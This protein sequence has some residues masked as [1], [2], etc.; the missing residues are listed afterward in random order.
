MNGGP[1]GATVATVH[2]GLCF[3]EKRDSDKGNNHQGG[4]SDDHVTDMISCGARSYG[5]L[6]VFS[7]DRTFVRIHLTLLSRDW[8]AARPSLQLVEAS[9]VPRSPDE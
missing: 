8:G 5:Y 7:D 9:I 1:K 6:V 2:S 4:T 3:D